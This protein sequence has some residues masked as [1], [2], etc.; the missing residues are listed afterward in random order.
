MQSKLKKKGKSIEID[1]VRHCKRFI[2]KPFNAI[3]PF[4]FVYSRDFFVTL[5]AES[6][7]RFIQIYKIQYLTRHATN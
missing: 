5:G 7:S 6:I 3:F 1:L 4:L 2:N